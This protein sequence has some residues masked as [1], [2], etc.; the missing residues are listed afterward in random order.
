M[1]IYFI[2][3]SVRSQLWHEVLIVE[4][5]ILNHWTTRADPCLH[6]YNVSFIETLWTNFDIGTHLILLKH[7]Q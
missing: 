2:F 5:Q 3:G 1:F 4:R 6:N 7:I